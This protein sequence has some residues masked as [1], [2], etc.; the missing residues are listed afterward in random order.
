MST[1]RLWKISAGLAAFE[2]YAHVHFVHW[3]CFRFRRTR[4]SR[5]ERGRR[6]G[7]RAQNPTTITRHAL[8]YYLTHLPSTEKPEICPPLLQKLT[9]NAF[10]HKRSFVLKIIS[11]HQYSAHLPNCSYDELYGNQ[12][13]FNRPHFLTESNVSGPTS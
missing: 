9:H 4:N 7:L 8:Y 13:I 3:L 11:P 2:A 1:S 10:K 5:C 6:L 12:F